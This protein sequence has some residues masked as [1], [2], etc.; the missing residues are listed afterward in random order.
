MKEVI[1]RNFVLSLLYTALVN[2]IFFVF[3]II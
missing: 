3:H 1:I 2:T